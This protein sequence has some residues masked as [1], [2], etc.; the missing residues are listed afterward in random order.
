[1]EKRVSYDIRSH[2]PRYYYLLF[3]FVIIRKGIV[4]L[5]VRL[6]FMPDYD[7]LTR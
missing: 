7:A 5:R 3:Y 2:L 1:M 4:S 6:L